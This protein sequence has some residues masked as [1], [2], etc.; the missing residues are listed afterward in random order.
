MGRLPIIAMGLGFLSIAAGCS[1][2]RTLTVPIL[3]PS[4]PSLSSE[5]ISPEAGAIPLWTESFDTLDSHRWR[6]IEIGGQ[7]TYDIVDLEG[8]KCLRAS[9]HHGASML[10]TSVRFRPDQYPWLS[11]RWRIEQSVVGEDLQRK[12]GSDASARIY[13]YF[14]SKG[15][16]W[17]K[18]NLDFVWSDHL[19]LNTLFSSAFASTSKILVVDGGAATVGKWRLIERNLAE[20]YRR[21]FGELPTRVIAV[22]IMTDTDTMGGDVVTYYDEFRVTH[23]PLL[24]HSSVESAH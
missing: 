15:L 16:P 12:E 8:Q 2:P 18:R 22:G 10:V 3:P 6:E 23:A 1:S 7:T 4:L 17:Q 13:V 24:T 9:S 21:A 19:P 14:D 20:D 11:W 5:P